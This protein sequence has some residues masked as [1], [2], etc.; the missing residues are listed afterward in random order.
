MPAPAT[1]IFVPIFSFAFSFARR[2]HFKKGLE[3][4]ADPSFDALLLLRGWGS[5]G[6]YGN[7][8][9]L[10]DAIIDVAPANAPAPE[11]EQPDQQSPR[12]PHRHER[13]LFP[14]PLLF[15]APDTDQPS[16]CH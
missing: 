5:Y 15:H 14:N 4:E 7:E 2:I 16:H 3:R 11:A 10:A 13:H 9:P 6:S 1:A 12:V 8:H